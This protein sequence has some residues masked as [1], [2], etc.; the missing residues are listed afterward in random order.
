MRF[1]AAALVA[2]FTLATASAQQDRRLT[3]APAAEARRVALVIGNGAYESAPLRN[4]INDARDVA[5]ALRELGFDVA[6]G[7]N[8]GRDDMKRRIRSFGERLR[9]G[10][11]VAL[12]YY[13]GH[14]VQVKGTN[15]L[16]PVDAKVQ[17]E[18]EVEYEGVEAGFVLAQMEADSSRV[19][20]VIL[21]A[22][23]NNPFTRSFRSAANGLAALD[24]PR[25]TLIAYATGPGSTASDGTA[26]NGLYTQEL[27]KQMRSPG[28]SVEDVFKRVRVAV[29]AQTAGRQTP[30]ESSSLTGDFR[31]VN[32]RPLPPEIVIPASKFA[33]GSNVEVGVLRTFGTDIVHNAAPYVAGTP[34]EV[35]YRITVVEGGAYEL[36]V[37]LAAAEPRPVDIVLNG[38]VAFKNALAVTS[39]SWNQSD[40]KWFRAGRL[41][42]QPGVNSLIIRR[43][44]AFPH[45]LTVRLTPSR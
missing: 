32:G 25:G 35:E 27:L 1:T 21:D 7:E 28:L 24:A 22:C 33:R 37:Q 14:G 20:I 34:N 4:P 15:Y 36:S 41:F 12:F 26:R 3:V 29:L 40:A 17:R 31:F 8:L 44:D 19:N 43:A 16:V 5:Q 42:L 18:E 11:D 39:G 10:S 23:R 13:A 2:A 38:A 9:G 6:H 30:W 45:L